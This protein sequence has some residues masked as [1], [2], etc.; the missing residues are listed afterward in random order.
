MTHYLT[1]SDTQ[2]PLA[3][4]LMDGD[5]PVDIT[6][7]T[8]KVYGEDASGNAWITEG[9]TGVT[10]HPTQTFTADA[11]TDKIKA[12]AHKLKPGQQIQV[13]NSGG[14]LPTGLAA[15]TRYFVINAEPNAFQVSLTPGGDAVDITAAGSGTHSLWLIGSVQYEFQTADVASAGQF[16]LWFVVFDGSSKR[17]TYPTSGDGKNSPGLAVY[18]GARNAA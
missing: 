2:K 12:N 1:V 18:V 6:G 4:A 3:A 17:A 14:A 5:D 10:V 16:Y 7:L 15:S 11:S 13:S 9:T 8:V